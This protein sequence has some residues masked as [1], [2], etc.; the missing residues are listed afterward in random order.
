VGAIGRTD[1][2]LVPVG[3]FFTID[4]LQAAEVVEALSPSIVIPMHYKTPKVDFPIAGVE[5]F[6][7]TQASVEQKSAPTVEIT[8]ATLPAERITYVLQ[9]AR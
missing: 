4:H 9:P 1:V 5:P 2:L 7:A 3:G 6:L 8:Q